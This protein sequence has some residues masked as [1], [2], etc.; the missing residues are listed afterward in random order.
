MINYHL[1]ELMDRHRNQE[2]EEKVSGEK[3]KPL[4]SPLEKQKFRR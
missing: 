3:S 1:G 4:V 2:D